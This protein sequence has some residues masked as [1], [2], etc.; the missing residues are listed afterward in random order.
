MYPSQIER[1][2][3]IVVQ[4]EGVYLENRSATVDKANKIFFK[5]VVLR[6]QRLRPEIIVSL[7]LNKYG[8]YAKLAKSILVNGL[9]N[10]KGSGTEV[11][12]HC[13]LPTMRIERMNDPFWDRLEDI[14]LPFDI[15][16]DMNFPQTE[17]ITKYR[18]FVQQLIEQ[19]QNV[20][21][22]Y[23]EPLRA[24]TDSP[25][26]LRCKQGNVL[27][28]DSLYGTFLHLADLVSAVTQYINEFVVCTTDF[29]ITV[30]TLRSGPVLVT[31]ASENSEG[32]E[33][34]FRQSADINKCWLANYAFTTE[35]VTVLNNL[36]LTDQSIFFT[37]KNAWVILRLLS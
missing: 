12:P 22:S 13:P 8:K 37:P 16:F 21:E 5:M 27:V 23:S 19:Y 29:C 28:Y 26:T 9:L 15:S 25:C 17:Q 24:C 2:I 30:I 20:T 35:D 31:V 32:L 10:Y 3:D 14:P 34:M 6:T 33:S 7:V 11:S 36:S 1:L 18:D 4:N